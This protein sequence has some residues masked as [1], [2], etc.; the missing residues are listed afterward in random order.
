M[1][2]LCTALLLFPI[3]AAAEEAH[4]V[5][6]KLC[7]GCHARISESFR[8]TSMG[9][10][11]APASG[12]SQTQLAAATAAVTH[13]K[14]ER[15]LRVWREGQDL[16]Q[17]E[18]QTGVFETKFRLDYVIGSGM[19][20]Y[21]Y[22]VRRGDHLFQAPLSY[23]SRAAKWD[24]SPGYE[25]GDFAFSRPVAEGC[26]V[27]HSGRA[28]PVNGQTGRY[29]SPPF[30]EVAIGCENCH[31]PGSLHVSAPARPGGKR[32]SIV[33][34]AKLAPRLAEQICMYCHQG[35]DTRV[36]QP[37]K[38]YQDFRPGQWLNET[39][40]IGDLPSTE[41]DA[42]LLEHHS[43]MQASRCFRA[44]AGKLSCLT[45]HNPH[46][47]PEQKVAYY[48]QKCLGCHTQ[49]SC[50]APA[51]QRK[52]QGD[53]CTAC[54]MPKRQDRMISHSALTNHRIV[55]RP[56]APAPEPRAATNGIVYVNATP[57]GKPLADLTLLRMYGELM[58]RDPGLQERY[59]TLLEKIA[60][61]EPENP[62][63]LA[64]LG[65]KEVRENNAAATEKAIGHLSR[66]LELG[67]TGSAAFED[68]AEAL[69]RA[70]RDADAVSVLQRGL[71]LEPFAPVLHKSLTLRYIN[72]KSY[73][74]ARAA[75]KR[76]VEL[77]PEDSFMRGLLA[78]VGDHP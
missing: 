50:T 44:S 19:N 54:H 59:L 35:G 71:Q 49:S 38:R 34:P 15:T 77:F 63:V 51:V 66:A 29:E 33:N 22:L 56:G 47:E 52:T 24:L 17:S 5:G 16:Y 39:L 30:T 36:L 48:R 14:V 67:F 76:Y 40:A 57:G 23:Y 65:R 64:A 45:C 20:G 46:S 13:P 62:L 37:G 78:Q 25:S 75:M 70:G 26:I 53:D 3:L 2:S 42:D 61:S 28:R 9:R 6:S 32:G 74:E 27:C 68:L 31:G 10:S 41:R 73:E 72:L 18:A 43:A 58:D 12:D 4:Y 1:R 11:M 55:R 8:R 21:T 69:S 60:R 7:A